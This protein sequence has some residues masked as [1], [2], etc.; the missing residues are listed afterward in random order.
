MTEWA[1]STAGT[2]DW[3]PKTGSRIVGYVPG[4]ETVSTADLM[5]DGVRRSLWD[6]AL[7]DERFRSALEEGLADFRAGRVGPVG[8]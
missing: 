3:L 6:E 4:F 5:G 1:N 2:R 7:A 8:E